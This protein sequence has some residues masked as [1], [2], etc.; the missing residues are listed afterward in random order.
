M[1]GKSNP[2]FLF[3][4][5]P[6]C[7]SKCQ[8]R[9]KYIEIPPNQTKKGFTDRRGGGGPK[10]KPVSRSIKIDLQFPVG[11]IGCYLKNGCYSQRVRIGALVYLA[12]VLECLPAEVN[13]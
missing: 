2:R 5:P 13:L 9:R 7:T 11:G 1:H 4:T 10:K 8:A 12:I 6:S 3:L